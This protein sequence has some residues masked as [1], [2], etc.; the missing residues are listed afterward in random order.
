[1][2]IPVRPAKYSL[3]DPK[4]AGTTLPRTPSRSFLLAIVACL[5]TLLA[6]ERATATPIADKKAR[7]RQI[8]AEVTALDERLEGVIEQYN[9][10]NMKLAS[11]RAQ[12]RENTKL[13]K[14]AEYNL[15]VANHNLAT[16][17]VALYKQQPVDLLDVLL[18][19]DSFEELASQVELMSRLGEH[20][21]EIIA[22]V[23]RYRNAM[24]RQ[25]AALL[26]NREAAEKLVAE[27]KSKKNAIEK[28]LA[29]RRGMLR[30]VEAE[31]RRME[32]EEAER[33]RRIVENNSRHTNERPIIPDAG[34]PGHPEVCA[35]AARYLGVPYKYGGASPATGFDCSGFVMYVYAQIGIS[36]PHYSGAQQQLGTP[37]AMNALLPGDLVFRGFPAYHVGIYVGSGMVIHSPHTGA[38]VSYQSV[39][40]WTSAVRL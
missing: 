38:V 34:G 11:V 8:R 19:T 24:R 36:L 17:A 35:I 16:R 21:A 3:R 7:A 6:V 12:M 1:M 5:L 25:R 23:K 40:G 9:A 29:T 14:I 26:S 15:Q 13:Y 2:T 4:E 20:D 27:A 33:A 28:T 10:A 18:Q 39:S 37:V 32:R 30:G 22:A 31:I